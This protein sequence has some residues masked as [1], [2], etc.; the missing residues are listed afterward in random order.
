MFD[1]CARTPTLEC[2]CPDRT[3]CARSFD[4]LLCRHVHGWAKPY[5]SQGTHEDYYSE[6]VCDDAALPYP[7]PYAYHPSEFSNAYVMLR[8]P[9]PG[10]WHVY[11][12]VQ[13]GGG[14]S[15]AKFTWSTSS[16]RGPFPP[17]IPSPSKSAIN[18]VAHTPPASSLASSAPL[19]RANV[20]SKDGTRPPCKYMYAG[21]QLASNC[22][23]LEP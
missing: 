21:K 23:L 15:T 9:G 17:T 18:C 12:T 14:V 3:L 11:A 19:P 8:L 1:W 5:K 16:V 13:R 20:S 4:L 2:V 7:I 6:L 22:S 10:R